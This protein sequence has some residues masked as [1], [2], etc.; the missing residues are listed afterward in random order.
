MAFFLP[1]LRVPE[2]YSLPA[3]LLFSQTLIKL[4]SN[5][6]LSQFLHSPINITKNPKEAQISLVTEMAN[7]ISGRDRKELMYKVFI[8]LWD[9]REKG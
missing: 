1:Y 2:I 3:L 7:G 5:F 4:P 9:E 8:Q 6:V